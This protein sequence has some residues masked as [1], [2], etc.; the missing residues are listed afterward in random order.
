[1]SDYLVENGHISPAWTL[2]VNGMQLPQDASLNDE[3][4][5]NVQMHL[6]YTPC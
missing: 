3:I 2:Y 5:D 4:K 6:M 1:M